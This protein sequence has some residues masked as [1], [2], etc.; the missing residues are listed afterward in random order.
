MTTPSTPRKAGPL[1][2]T[3]AQT[4]WPF[5]FKVFAASDIA[6]TIANNL[7]VETALVL[8]ADYSVTLNSNQD[9]SP[10]GTVTYPIS[11]SALP[12]GSKLT[13]FGNLPYD[14][15]LDLPSGGNF[16]PLALENQLDRLTM[17]IQQ[18]REQVGRSLTVPVT[19]GVSP[20]LPAPA[21]SNIIGW[22]ENADNLENYPLS[23]L[24]TSLAFA[25]YRYDTFTG[26]GSTTQF[27]LSA[28]PVTLGNLDVAVGGVT[29]TPGADYLLVTGVIEFTSAPPLGVT[30]L[31]RFGEGIASGPASDSY[32]VRFRQAG[33]GS[34][35]RTAEAKMRETVSVKDFGAVGDGVTD[36]TAA[37]QAAINFA[38][39]SKDFAVY[40][41]N[42]IKA[43]WFP[44]GVY[45]VSNLLLQHK[46]STDDDSRSFRIYGNG[47]RIEQISGS[48]GPV[49]EISSCKRLH[50]SDLQIAGET[51]ITGMWD[52]IFDNVNFNSYTGTSGYGVKFG[53]RY[54]AGTDLFDACY[55]NKFT[56]C[57]FSPTQFDVYGVDDQEFNANTF[58][59]CISEGIEIVGNAN[60]SF[61]GNVWLGGE[62]RGNP[63]ISID[64]ARNS[65][66][67][68]SLTLISTYFDQPGVQTNL[69]DFQMKML[70][71][72]PAPNDYVIDGQPLGQAGSVQELGL[73]GVRQGQRIPVSA[74]NL[75]VN[76][77]LNAAAVGETT[78]DGVSLF[79]ASAL[80]ASTGG[81]GQ[82]AKYVT[83]ATTGASSEAKYK[84]NAL[85]FDGTYTM[86][87]VYRKPASN[88]M[89]VR[90]QSSLPGSDAY[91]TFANASTLFV[92]NWVIASYTFYANASDEVYAVFYENTA[93]KTID[94]AYV[95]CTLGSTGIIFAAGAPSIA[96]QPQVV[97]RSAAPT[98]GTWI[99]GSIAWNTTPSAAG[100]PGWVC[101][102]AGTPGTWKAMANLAA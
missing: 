3:G 68:N 98:T 49:L 44:A 100:T 23:E 88:A 74:A 73:A 51:Y 66:T 38:C 9:T 24:A 82:F 86:N 31:A 47:V 70:G 80:V 55:W 46:L 45:K 84:T 95:G 4:S 60:G 102:T 75:I 71:T 32:D 101:V 67:P 77:D 6:V 27:T 2:G 92:G 65:P 63:V 19:S 96:N 64:A 62:L 48:T 34:V 17:Q 39:P 53:T 30:I 18:L 50:V 12:T 16:S 85:P 99:R 11:G 54:A 79:N 87:I 33:T 29:Q 83:Y 61:Q 8:N 36:D 56:R 59:S 41:A 42:E 10:G 7:G 89:N 25:T 14:Q 72:C 58:D 40:T 52:S 28:D 5:T 81:V 94:V 69:Y 26:D 22:N 97:W 37:I 1:L 76:G 91:N 20:S 13:I 93:G 43:L 21:A 90:F 15:P 57:R 35:D 78:V